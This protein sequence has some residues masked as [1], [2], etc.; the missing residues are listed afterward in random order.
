M[1]ANGIEVPTTL[2]WWGRGSWAAQVCVS[3]AGA[4]EQ[5]VW[6]ACETA[7]GAL[8]ALRQRQARDRSAGGPR[9][10]CVGLAK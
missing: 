3:A 7:G 9:A 10:C 4:P 1:G 2:S 6:H 5:L 8:E